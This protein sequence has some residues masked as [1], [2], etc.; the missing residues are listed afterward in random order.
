MLLCPKA[1]KLIALT[2]TGLL[3]VEAVSTAHGQVVANQTPLV[4]MDVLATCTVIA[5][6]GALGGFA[7]SLN[8]FAYWPPREITE[9]SRI[10]E[11]KG[12][13]VY[14]GY[15]EG[16][17]TPF[18]TIGRNATYWAVLMGIV[19]GIAGAFGLVGV[20]SLINVFHA[21]GDF[22]EDA[23]DFSKIFGVSVL[24]GYIAR[25]A[26]P[27]LGTA[28]TERALIN[29]QNRVIEAESKVIEAGTKVEETANKLSGST[30]KIETATV[31]VEQLS[32]T[33]ELQK[34]MI[35]ELNASFA[36]E[37]TKNALL[38]LTKID[39]TEWEQAVT[40][41]KEIFEKRNDSRRAAILYARILTER[42][43][44]DNA[45]PE[46]HSAI[47]VLD[48]YLSSK[49]KNKEDESDVLFNRACYCLKICGDAIDDVSK[50]EWIDKS[51]A[52]LRRSV[53]LKPDNK[54]AAAEDIDFKPVW[55]NAEFLAITGG[56]DR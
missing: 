26:L 40:G 7:Q 34:I 30:D 4:P 14:F 52:D 48:K 3:S 47:D 21:Q 29:A 24:G 51:L 5:I 35:D 33:N 12:H 38:N 18:G 22:A 9:I 42:R 56:G 6:G 19:V 31:A 10:S 17:E 11:G 37:K 27:Q 28:M 53:E 2:A 15:K 20:F 13:T 49:N 25:V 45:K 32:K 1:Y 43:P 50:K 23:Y 54:R 16:I 36:V 41:I 8:R 39:Q 46:Y 55:D 44:T